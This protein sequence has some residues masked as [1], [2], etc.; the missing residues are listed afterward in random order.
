MDYNLFR[1]ESKRRKFDLIDF[2][3]IME[4]FYHDQPLENAPKNIVKLYEKAKEAYKKQRSTFYELLCGIS[5]DLCG[6]E[7]QIERNTGE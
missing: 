4:G 3:E 6:D 1:E 2:D 5:K 7:K